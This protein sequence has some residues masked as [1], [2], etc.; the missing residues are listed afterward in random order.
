MPLKRFEMQVR[1]LTLAP[2]LLVCLVL[3]QGGVGAHLAGRIYL[4]LA[5]LAPVLLVALPA[6]TPRTRIAW[7]AA[8][9]LILTAIGSEA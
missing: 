7:V 5:L 2:S 3:F 6:T 9:I 4:A 8:A 1:A